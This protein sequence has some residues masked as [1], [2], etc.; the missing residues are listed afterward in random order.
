MP[1]HHCPLMLH[2]AQALCAETASR[3]V[4]AAVVIWRSHPE[5]ALDVA[6]VARPDG[7]PRDA[8]PVRGHEPAGHAADV[9]E[10]AGHLLAVQFA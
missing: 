10:A 5:Q 2:V 8:P 7:R 9:A 3:Q 6:Q 4:Y 1:Q